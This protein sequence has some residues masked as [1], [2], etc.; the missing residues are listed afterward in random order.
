MTNRAAWA[1]LGLMGATA[2]LQAGWFGKTAD[3]EH[4]PYIYIEPK[5][6]HTAPWTLER[7][8]DPQNTHRWAKPTITS[9]YKAGWIGGSAFGKR[10]E[11]RQPNEGTWGLDY[12]GHY[13]PKKVFLG[14]WH[15]PTK[16]QGDYDR[17]YYTEHPDGQVPI[18]PVIR[19]F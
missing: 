11:P 6:F 10:G 4:K 18:L 16:E 13:I 12:T 17:Q 1:L 3:G 9:H 5:V 19:Q 15:R 8:G 7:A 2:P 14:W